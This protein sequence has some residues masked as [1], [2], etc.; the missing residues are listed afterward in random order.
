MPDKKLN[1]IPR[2]Q[3][4][5][6]DKG[7]AALHRNNFDYAIAIFNQVL[8]Q[9]PAFYEC[10][11]ALRAT[12]FKKAGAGPGFLKKFLGSAGSSPLIARAQMALRSNPA[13]A[14]HTLEQVL[15]SDPH[16]ATAHKLLADAALQTDLPRAAALSLEIVFKNS[17]KDRDLG[18]KLGDALGKAGQ[19]EKADKVYSDLQR[20]YPNDPEIAQAHKN[21]AASRTLTEGGYNALADGQGSYRD[22]LRDKDEAVALEQEHRTVKADDVASHL[23]EEYELRLKKEPGNLKLLRDI[24]ELYVQK[25]DFDQA[26]K[27]YTFIGASESGSDPSLERTIAATTIKKYDFALSHLDPKAQDYEE[28][29]ARLRGERDA[30]QLAECQRRAE[31]YPS[32]LQIR[33]ELGELYFQAGKIGEAIQEFQRAQS[34][35][36][37]RVRSLHYLGRCFAHRG[38]NDLAA[39]TLQN[40]I[41]EK[42]VFDEEK[43]ELIYSLGCVFEQMGQRDSAI[44]QFEQIYAVDIG[45]KDVAA[46]VDAYYAAKQ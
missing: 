44:K 22:I 4:E 35:P 10:R 43:K 34:N 15:N 16:N 46:K 2:A 27:Y 25:K 6:Y 13:E 39:R 14:I 31:R 12:Q 9:E 40:A 28:K 36:N 8:Q 7:M 3:R 20:L 1:E 21:L 37:L 18:L 30:F 45:Y 29:A 38:M 11:E 23:I 41:K 19:V 26:L 5:Q 33:F 17:P 24:A 42:I 32:D